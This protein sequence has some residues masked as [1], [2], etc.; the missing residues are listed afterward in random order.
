MRLTG[1]DWFS[2]FQRLDTERVTTI[3]AAL[4]R[5]LTVVVVVTLVDNLVVVALHGEERGTSALPRL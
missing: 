3:L 2:G 1:F 5:P 4:H